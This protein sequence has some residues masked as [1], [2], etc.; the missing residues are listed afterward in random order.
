MEKHSTYPLLVVLI[1]T[2]MGVIVADELQNTVLRR[3]NPG[4]NYEFD[5]RNDVIRKR[6]LLQTEIVSSTTIAS[7]QDKDL[8]TKINEFYADKN[9]MAMFCVLPVMIII[10]GG[11]SAIY[12]AAKCRRYIRKRHVRLSG[13]DDKARL[14]NKDQ[15]DV[16]NSEFISIPPRG[17]DSPRTFISPGAPMGPRPLPWYTPT[18]P[19]VPSP[20]PPRLSRGQISRQSNHSD[21]KQRDYKDILHIKQ[22]MYGTNGHEHEPQAH[23]CHMYRMTSPEHAADISGRDS[24]MSYKDELLARFDALSTFTMAKKAANILRTGSNSTKKEPD[25]FNGRPKQKMIFIAE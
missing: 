15:N 24:V 12:C 23:I 1:L 10:Y 14:T 9:N 18:D 13:H 4:F 20:V 6:H 7:P 2:R 11:C 17:T 25:L 19:M 21:E 8:L 5:I 3:K 16:S 22:P